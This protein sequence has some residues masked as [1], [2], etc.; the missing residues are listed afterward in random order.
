MSKYSPLYIIGTKVI[1]ENILA[2][3]KNSNEQKEIYSYQ[4]PPNLMWM[5]PL[6]IMEMLSQTNSTFFG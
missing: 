4:H 2:S 5:V 3:D 1:S 6:Q